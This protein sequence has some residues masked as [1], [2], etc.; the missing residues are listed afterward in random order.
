[1]SVPTQI[2]EERGIKCAVNATR[3]DRLDLAQD[4]RSEEGGLAAGAHEE[5]HLRGA[6]AGD[7]EDSRRNWTVVELIKV[8][9]DVHGVLDCNHIE[10]EPI[11]VITPLLSTKTIHIR[12]KIN[13]GNVRSDSRRT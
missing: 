8:G 9:G 12:H 4:H 2:S 13:H 1:M 6:I 7:C 10:Y 3:T 11:S 5:D